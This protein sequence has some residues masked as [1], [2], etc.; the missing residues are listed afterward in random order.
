MRTTAHT[1]G[2]AVLVVTAA[3]GGTAGARQACLP[4]VR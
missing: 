1:L 2:M 4:V 3:P